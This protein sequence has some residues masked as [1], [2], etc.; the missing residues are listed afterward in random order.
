MSDAVKIISNNRWREIEYS[1]PDWSEEEE[2]CFQYKNHTYYLSEFMRIEG[3]EHPFKDYHGYL[4]H[5]VWS[6]VLIKL[7]DAGDAVIVARYY[8]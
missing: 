5:T 6:G 3:D 4:N 2:P 7:H 8:S 1:R